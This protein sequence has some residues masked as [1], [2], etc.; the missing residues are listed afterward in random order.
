MFKMKS[1]NYN[2]W[3]K[4]RL[5]LNKNVHD[6]LVCALRPAILFSLGDVYFGLPLCPHINKV[7]KPYLKPIRWAVALSIF[8]NTFLIMDLYFQIR[9]LQNN[10]STEEMADLIIMMSKIL[11]SL[12]FSTSLLITRTEFQEYINYCISLIEKRKR[13]GL[14]SILDRK[15]T[16]RYRGFAYF[17]I[18]L[19]IVFTCF[20]SWA[21]ALP[22]NLHFESLVK[23]FASL[24]MLYIFFNIALYLYTSLEIYNS[25]FK[26][27]YNNIET[28]LME[29]LQDTNKNKRKQVFAEVPLID[30]VRYSRQFYLCLCRLYNKFMLRGNVIY[31]TEQVAEIT[32]IFVFCF[33]LYVIYRDQTN[34]WITVDFTIQTLGVL[35]SFLYTNITVHF[36]K[37]SVSFNRLL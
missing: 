22:K 12:L 19:Y 18:G 9:K 1:L 29:A 35:T 21:I 15:T 27:F 7:K 34:W 36:I 26:V 6:C 4:S 32:A 8:F 3:L 13:F 17:S 25:T 30:R 28:V 37:E 16:A 10:L 11:N 14:E 33:Q 2:T 31:Y 24:L 20:Y 23:Y 5:I